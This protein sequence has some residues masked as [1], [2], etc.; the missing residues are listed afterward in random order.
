MSQPKAPQPDSTQSTDD[1]WEEREKA[2]AMVVREAE[3][4]QEIS[5]K[6]REDIWLKECGGW[7][8]LIREHQV[9]TTA[10]IREG[11]N[12]LSELSDRQV[13]S[14]LQ[15]QDLKVVMASWEEE[16][17][18]LSRQI[19]QSEVTSTVKVC[20]KEGGGERAAMD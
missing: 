9:S 14:Y 13:L 19:R 3:A 18:R 16:N 11:E 2:N 12:Y 1:E 20:G 6:Q 7:R 15:D 8:Q 4:K 5:E 17:S 10:H